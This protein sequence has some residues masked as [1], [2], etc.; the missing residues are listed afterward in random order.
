VVSKS[1]I[2]CDTV[3]WQRYEQESLK[4]IETKVQDVGTNEIFEVRSKG[5]WH[6]YKL[7]RVPEGG[8][9]VCRANKFM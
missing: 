2:V 6:K 5:S 3:K 7:M 1:I 9:K 8:T 4:Y